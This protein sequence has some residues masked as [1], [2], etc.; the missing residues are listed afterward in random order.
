M[1]KENIFLYEK[2]KLKEV[3]E[4]INKQIKEA[5]ENFSKQEHTIIGF[6]EGQRGTQFIRQGLMSLYATEIYN[7]KSVLSNPYFGMFNFENSEEK[8]EIYLGKKT[9]MDGTKV[10]AHD[11]RSPIC[12]MYYDYNIGDAEYISNTG[13]KR[14][15]QITTKRQIII[16][17]G[18]LKD[19]DDQDTLSNDAVLLKYLKENSDARLKSI[20]ATIQREQNKIIR[21]PLRGDYI[22][23]G[24]AGSG[25]T[26]VALHRIAYLLYNEVKNISEADFMILGPN[27][28]FLNYISELLPDLDIKNISQ[29]TFEEIA[30]KYM[31][32]SKVK[33]ESK[34]K[35]LQ[36]VLAGNVEG[37][38][39]S[40]KS[41][42]KFLRLIEKFVD[43]YVQSHLKDDIEYEGLKICSVE[44]MKPYFNKEVF[45]IEKGYSERANQYIK[46]LIKKIKDNSDDLAHNI[47]L[48]YRDEYLG[49]PKDSPRRKEI[50]DEVDKI[51]MEIKKGCPTSIKNYFKFM[52]VNPLALYQSFIENLNIF[53]QNDQNSLKELQDYT[54]SRLS[55]KQIGFED[56]SPLL[57]INYSLNGVKDFKD[58]SYLVID[59]AQDLSLAQY[60]VLKKL[61]PSAK[62]NVFGD[63]NQSVYDYQSIHDWDELNKVIFNNKAN[64][65]D[66]NK[67]YRTTVN[68]SNASNL[69]L[70]HL[71]QNNSECVAR[72]GNEIIVSNDITYNNLVSQIKTLLDKEYQSVA[73]ICKDEKESNMVYKKLSKLGLNVSVI[74][75]KNEEY[76]GGLC[77]MPSYL[78]KGLEFDAVILYN[79]NNINYTDSYIDSKL[80]YVAMT[81]AMHELY[82]NYNGEL[83][84]ALKSLSKNKKILKRTK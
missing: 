27:K 9:I 65:L 3:I 58:F 60:Y 41:S 56:L 62:F 38:V 26:T 78:S 47:W 24:T 72:P 63:V 32:I 43:F 64:M 75:E 7:L 31:G 11:W 36:E 52:K 33:L 68:I 13:E 34:N 4:L 5:E 20:I 70:S 83:P 73:I 37:K 12:S 79:A 21:S 35:T 54:L 1:E 77:I 71:G 28:Y 14:K 40:D 48:R 67:S 16:K 76:H 80:L 6:K 23:Q 22:I 53:T 61:F 49:L 66:L 74:T 25:K 69:I 19:V 82:V 46:I 50:L 57:L 45:S 17:D 59:E 81:R 15:G 10:I 18:I 51:Q 42:I 8:N 39:I 55:K 84:I 29:L 30:M 44:D 2:N